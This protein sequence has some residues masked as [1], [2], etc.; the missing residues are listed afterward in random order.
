MLSTHFPVHDDFQL[1]ICTGLEDLDEL[2][3]KTAPNWQGKGLPDGFKPDLRTTISP[4]E[5]EARAAKLHPACDPIV[6][7]L[8]RRGWTYVPLD[9]T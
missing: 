8:V 1:V 5:G 3:S 4:E 9:P 6:V 2:A 7:D